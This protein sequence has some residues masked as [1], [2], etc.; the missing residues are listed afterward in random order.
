M[1]VMHYEREF[2]K[3]SGCPNLITAGTNVSNMQVVLLT[4]SDNKARRN[5]FGYDKIILIGYD[6]SWRPDGKY[7]A[8][9]DDGGGKFHYM[10]HIHGIG[11]GGRMVF[12]SNNLSGSASWLDLYIK[13]YKLPVVQCSPD[14]IAAFGGVRDLEK[15]LR[16][17]F[18]REDKA[19]V[20]KLLS[21]KMQFEEQLKVVN[22]KLKNLGR[23][24]HYAHLAS[25]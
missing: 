12:T 5:F 17:S 21:K 10:R 13:A 14:T 22:D 4:Q 3:L 6:Y 1:D 18:Q 2:S 20:L 16:Y 24:H 7:Y 23:A 8:F 11:A 9:D 15:Q 19:T 25:V